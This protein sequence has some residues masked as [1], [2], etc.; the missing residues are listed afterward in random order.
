VTDQP[1]NPQWPPGVIDAGGPTDPALGPQPVDDV[2]RPAAFTLM[3]PGWY[4][5]ENAI[6]QSYG[7]CFT[8]DRLVVLVQTRDD[9]WNLPGGQLEAGETAREALVREVAEEACA[10]V[11]DCRYLA[12]QHVWDPQ[13]P[14][15]PTS[16]Y[17]TRWWARV[18]L[19]PWEPHHEMVPRLPV[20]PDRV[21]ATLSW[22]SRAIAG[23]LLDAAMIQDRLVRDGAPRSRP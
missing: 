13:A 23:C 2:D 11:I 6:T 5:P 9:F 8:P 12:C 15:G 21:L 3:A 20:P 7:F 10:R 16:H 19:D 14:H 1:E 17:Q 4:P 18:E 22:R